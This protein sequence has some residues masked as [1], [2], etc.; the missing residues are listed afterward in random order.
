VRIAAVPGSY[1][2]GHFCVKG[3]CSST[4]NAVRDIIAIVTIAVLLY[5]I[6]LLAL[7]L[8]NYYKRKAGKV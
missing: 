1:V 8:F 2:I 3:A 6:F 5:I 4:Y 7:A